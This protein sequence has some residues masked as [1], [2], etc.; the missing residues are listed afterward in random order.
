MTPDEV[1]MLDNRY[2][3]LFIR[4]ERPI[5][6]L[7]YDITHHPNVDRTT[8]GKAQPYKHGKKD[9]SA[10]SIQIVRDTGKADDFENDDVSDDLVILTNED[11]NEILNN[12]SKEENSK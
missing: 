7:K 2:A 6:D 11:I 1:R 4:G 5:I 3:L 8:D 12:K 9:F 10:A